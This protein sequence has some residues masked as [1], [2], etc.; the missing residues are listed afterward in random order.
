[1]LKLYIA[2]SILDSLDRCGFLQLWILVVTDVAAVNSVTYLYRGGDYPYT[3]NSRH[4]D[5]CR[6]GA[7][8]DS[9][10]RGFDSCRSRRPLWGELAG[11]EICCVDQ[12]GAPAS[13]VMW[14]GEVWVHDI[15]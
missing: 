6:A 9:W 2:N 15:P 7:R 5:V 12:D 14:L 1:V 4:S 8:L 13:S 11:V 3:V 10:G